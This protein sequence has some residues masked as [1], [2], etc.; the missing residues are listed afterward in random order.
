MVDIAEAAFLSNRLEGV[1]ASVDARAG[2]FNAALLLET[3]GTLSG[4]VAKVLAKAFIAFACQFSDFVSGQPSVLLRF[5]EQ[6]AT[7]IKPL[8]FAFTLGLGFV[9]RHFSQQVGKS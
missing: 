4:L 2:Q 7:F 8:R 6:E 5:S 1:I 3:L 9:G